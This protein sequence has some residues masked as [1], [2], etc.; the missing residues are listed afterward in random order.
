MKF[1]KLKFNTLCANCK[2]EYPEC[3]GSPVF[4]EDA[5]NKIFI[6]AINKKFL[7]CVIACTC[8][9]PIHEAKWDANKDI[10]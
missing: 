1:E 10:K 3:P 7:D 2:N 8:Y 9:T 4:I 6:G 5:C